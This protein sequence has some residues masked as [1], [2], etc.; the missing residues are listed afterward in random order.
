[1]ESQNQIEI[2]Q[3]ITHRISSTEGYPV[4]T[5]EEF[6]ADFCI[7]LKRALGISFVFINEPKLADI[8]T[9]VCKYF[10]LRSDALREKG[11]EEPLITYKMILRAMQSVFSGVPDYLIE[12]RYDLS[13]PQVSHAVGVV[14]NF[15]DARDKTYSDILNIYTHLN[16]DFIRLESAIK[17]NE[18]EKTFQYDK[19]KA[20]IEAHPI[21][22]SIKKSITNSVISQ[23][24]NYEH[25]QLN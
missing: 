10:N 11:R 17:P 15:I 25:V 12:K 18:K 1:M 19:L 8:E 24:A 5:N 4:K 22:K 21:T 16:A 23:A 3:K 9:Y 2:V 20:E 7:R 6:Y 13:H 14:R